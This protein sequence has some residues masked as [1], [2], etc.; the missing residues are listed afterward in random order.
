M[1]RINIIQCNSTVMK[2][3]RHEGVKCV[4]HFSFIPDK[5]FTLIKLHKLVYQNLISFKEF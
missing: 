2:K 1:G 5:N 3:L 4:F